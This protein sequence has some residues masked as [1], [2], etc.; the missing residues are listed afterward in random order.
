MLQGETIMSGA[1]DTCDECGIEL[2]LEVC[3][4][5]AGHY[6][7]TWCNC[8]PYSR[9]SGYFASRK[10]AEEALKSWFGGNLEN[11]RS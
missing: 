6:L 3:R 4:S 1:P 10:E 5:A 2:K 9:E 11:V 7:G 8:G